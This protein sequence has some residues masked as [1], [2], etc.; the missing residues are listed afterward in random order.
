[1]ELV[2]RAALVEAQLA[3]RVGISPS[4]VQ[5]IWRTSGLQPWRTE[6]TWRP[7]SRV[8]PGGR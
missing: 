7:G 4:S 3:R 5:G 6:T 8:K 2:A 1:M